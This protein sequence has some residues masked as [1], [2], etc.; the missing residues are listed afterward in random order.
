[1]T[2]ELLDN[3]YTVYKFNPDYTVKET[4]APV[5][6]YSVTKT[7][8]ELSIVAPSG[9]HTGFFRAETGWRIFK[10]EGTLDF[11]LIGVLSGIST[12]LAY[13]N[14]SIFVISTYDTDYIMIK[15]EKV[16]EA[17]KVLRENNYKLT[18]QTL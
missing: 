18:G 16:D 3:E 17:V 15:K 14:I 1:M 12:I 2:L 9:S 5:E 6:F 13:A 10:V 8:D 7:Y 11:S 4:I